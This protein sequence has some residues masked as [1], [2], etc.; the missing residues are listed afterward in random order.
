MLTAHMVGTEL[1]FV[2]VLR[3]AS[4]LGHDAVEVVKKAKIA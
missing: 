2:S 1:Y 3:E 4:G